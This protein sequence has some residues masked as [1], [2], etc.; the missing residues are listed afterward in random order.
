MARHSR[1]RSLGYRRPKLEKP[2]TNG[3]IAG[4]LRMLRT[5]GVS[6]LNRQLTSLATCSFVAGFA[7]ACLLVIVSEFAVS[8]A[9]GKR[10]LRVHGLT[11]SITDIVLISAALLAIYLAASVLAALNSSSMSSK[12]LASARSKMID[13]FFQRDGPCSPRNGSVT[14][15]SS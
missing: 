10:R 14:S 11:F 7:E 8:S 6:S 2:G 3:S 9:Q 5:L 13:A 12:A 4:T 1:P 15:S